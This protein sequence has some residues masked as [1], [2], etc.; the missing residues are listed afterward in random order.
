M[1][2]I[3]S[4]MHPFIYIILNNMFSRF[5]Q[6]LMLYEYFFAQSSRPTWAVIFK[7]SPTHKNKTKFH[8]AHLSTAKF[9]FPSTQFIL[10][11]NVKPFV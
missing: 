2:Q 11:K 5:A 4:T 1:V 3:Y 10:Y 7:S 8:P 9:L 6:N